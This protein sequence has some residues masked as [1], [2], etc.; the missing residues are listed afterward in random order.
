MAADLEDAHALHQLG[1]F[2]IDG[3]RVIGQGLLRQKFV[4]GLADPAEQI[5]DGFSSSLPANLPPRLTRVSRPRS[6]P[7]AWWGGGSGSALGAAAQAAAPISGAR[8]RARSRNY[9]GIM[10]GLSYRIRCGTS[11]LS[12]PQPSRSG[13]PKLSE[14]FADVGQD[15]FP[16][17]RLRIVRRRSPRHGCSHRGSLILDRVASG[18][19]RGLSQ[20][21]I[22][23]WINIA[24]CLSTSRSTEP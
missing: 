4:Q 1:D 17:T 18:Y 13:R 20:P 19:A 22:S 15:S 14:L 21:R 8:A 9:F 24:G 3:L 12:A 2:G 10:T 11:R 16:G 6:R 7:E 23:T 5:P